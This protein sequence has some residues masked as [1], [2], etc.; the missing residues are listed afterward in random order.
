MGEGQSAGDEG[1]VGELM[2]ILVMMI[3]VLEIQGQI[4]LVWVVMGQG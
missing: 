1:P 2:E 3:K 4:V